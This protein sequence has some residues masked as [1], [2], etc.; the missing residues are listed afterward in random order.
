MKLEDLGFDDWFLKKSGNFQHPDYSFARVTA[1][2]KNKFIIRNKETE[3]P[4]EIP[5]KVI[6]RATSNLDFPTVGDWVKIQYFDNNTFAIIHEILPRKSILK[7]KMAGARIEYQLIASN[8]DIVFIMQSIEHDYNISRLERYLIMANESN[9]EPV[10]LLSKI[11]LV[12]TDNLNQK[13]LE[14]KKINP[15]YKVIAFS[16]KTGEELNK[17]K[18][19]MK[20][21]KTYC[22]LGSSGV[23]KTTLLNNLIDKNLYS[24]DTV[25]K[26]DGRGRHVTTRRQLIILEQGSIVIDTPGMREL[27]N[28]GASKG[29]SETFSDITNLAQSCQFGDCTHTHEPGCSVLKAV[30]IG[31]LNKK[32]YQ[33]FLKLRRESEYNEM[34]YLE[35]RK[36]D[37]VFGNMIKQ[38]KK[39]IKKYNIKNYE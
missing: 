23:G 27:A 30:D 8:I 9:I 3:I 37:R 31:R 19:T 33:N 22:L 28:I 36:K 13:I 2:N 29:L 25:R 12:S 38:G 11:D 26:K 35:K 17:V 15:H 5:G 6:H 4:A 7:R 14:I 20:P 34:S 24:T 1:V 32:H 16:N 39:T 18:N 10:I 21:G